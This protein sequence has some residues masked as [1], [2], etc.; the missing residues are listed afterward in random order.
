MRAVE[1]KSLS[2]LSCQGPL[3][4]PCMDI[5]VAVCVPAILE[6]RS[7]DGRCAKVETAHV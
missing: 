1:P 5:G 2:L 6:T 7:D 3:G 4:L